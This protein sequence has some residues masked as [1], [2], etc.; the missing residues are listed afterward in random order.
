MCQG[1]GPGG[2]RASSASKPGK[3][4]LAQLVV[5]EEASFPGLQARTGFS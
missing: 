5:T 2:R 3:K 1:Q 4:G